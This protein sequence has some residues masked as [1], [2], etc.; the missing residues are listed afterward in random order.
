MGQQDPYARPTDTARLIRERKQ[1]EQARGRTYRVEA[2]RAAGAESPPERRWAGE[3]RPSTPYRPA[4]VQI[5]GS[6]PYEGARGGYGQADR[7]AARLARQTAWATRAYEDE[8]YDD[9]YDE[10]P[11]GLLSRKA[12]RSLLEFGAAAVFVLLLAFGLVMS[13]RKADAPPPAASAQDESNSALALLPF[14]PIPQEPVRILVMGSDIRPQDGGFRTDVMMLVTVDA[15]NGQISVLSFP[16]D[17]IAQAPGYGDT[18]IN[19][20]MG[21]GG[22]PLVQDTFEASYG[23]RPQY[24]F[25]SSFEGFSGLINSIDGIEVVA[26]ERLVDACDL[27]QSRAGICTVEPGRHRMDGA[28]A[29][30]YIRSRHTSSDFDRLRRAQEVLAGIFNR[31]MEMQ[32][33]LRMPELYDQYSVDFET[34]MSTVQIAGLLPTALQAANDASRIRR[35][36]VTREMAADWW[37][38][39]GA[40]VLLPDYE[41]V[42][43]LVKDAALLP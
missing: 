41:A 24:Y 32:A 6:R 5:T 14:A 10:A 28:T 4:Q 25:L 38:P 7:Q 13:Q 40:M 2:R 43:A 11:E 12:R 27:P 31:M 20:L 26:A 15:V 19:V 33:V 35:A 39:D 29:L 8:D 9:V 23:V 1:R 30:W 16:R 36:A 17:L 21:Y 22:F 34:N 42:R 3:P 37:M 18:R